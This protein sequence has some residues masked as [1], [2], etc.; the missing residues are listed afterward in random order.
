M[1]KRSDKLPAVLRTAAK[2]RLPP[3]A[4][5]RPGHEAALDARAELGLRAVRQMDAVLG[6]L[7]ARPARGGIEGRLDQAR[8][9]RPIGARELTSTA[10]VSAGL[11]ARLAG[12][13]ACAWRDVLVAED[14]AEAAGAGQAGRAAAEDEAFRGLYMRILTDGLAGELDQ[15][16]QDEQLG[17][18]SV[19]VLV[20]ALETGADTFLPFE[21]ALVAH[22][23]AEE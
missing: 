16:R 3:V 10:E 20:S 1:V 17:A 13:S 23:F 8:V 2:R 15:L 19:D 14:E 21:R 4:G 12:I 9:S 5:L 18:A 6:L 22:S 11:W 7:R